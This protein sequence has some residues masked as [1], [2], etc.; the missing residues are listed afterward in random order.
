MSRQVQLRRGT[1]AQ[2]S[3]FTGAAGEVTVD[4]SLDTLVVHDGSTAGGFPLVSAVGGARSRSEI[5]AVGYYSTRAAFVTA[6]SGG[7]TFDTGAVVIAGGFMYQK[8]ASSSMLSDLDDWEPLIWVYPQ[9]FGAAADGETEDGAAINA[10]LDASPR[11]FLKGSYLVDETIAQDNAQLIGQTQ[12]GTLRTRLIGSATDLDAEDAIIKPGRSFVLESLDIGYDTISGLEEQDQRVGIDCRGQTYVLQ[13]GAAIRNVRIDNVGTGI[14]D[15]GGS[16]FSV[17][18]D[19]IEIL[20]HSYAGVD[21]RGTVRT[22]NVWT[23]IYINDGDNNTPTYGFNYEGSETGGF[24]GQL[25]VEHGVYSGAAARFKNAHG[26]FIASLHIEGTDTTGTGKGYLE[27]E[28]S[29]PTIGKLTIQNQRMSYN[30]TMA[31]KL[32][33]APYRSTDSYTYRTDQAELIIDKFECKGLARPN[34]GLYP[35]YLTA[36]IGLANTLNFQFV[37]RSSDYTEKDYLVRIKSFIGFAYLATDEDAPYYKYWDRRWS[38]MNNNIELLETGHRG[39]RVYP[40]ENFVAN[41]AFERWASTSV[42]GVTTA[43]E[44]ADGWYV[45]GTT[46]AMAASRQNDDTGRDNNYYIQFQNT[47]GGNYQGLYTDIPEVRSLMNGPITVSFEMKASENGQRLEQITLSLVNA[48]G[49]P[50]SEFLQVVAGNDP[51]VS[52]TTS[53]RAYE[54]TIDGIDVDDISSFGSAPVLRLQFQITDAAAER[55]ST[56]DLRNVK[57]ER[58]LNATSFCEKRR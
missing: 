13:R 8:V 42:T 45:I 44:C 49:S 15:Y 54:F 28:E 32:G 10:A 16:T 6:V 52:I 39:T 34:T 9:H 55:L 38:N 33:N 18:Y 23:N 40:N 3:S 12:D 51:A 1:T 31:I 50:T 20:K 17:T 58:G 26:T 43:T 24:I 5:D 27:I 57:V 36:R 4:T 46:G 30:N 37:G 7:A 19:G 2:H 22:G 53:W 25:N 35:D 56:L 29:P 21:I 41:G 48:G 14:G 11:V 47:T